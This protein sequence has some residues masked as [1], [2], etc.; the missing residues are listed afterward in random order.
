MFISFSGWKFMFNEMFSGIEWFFDL[1]VI[2]LLVTNIYTQ[3][4]RNQIT[5]VLFLDRI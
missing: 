1:K 5:K 4:R 2:R 3:F